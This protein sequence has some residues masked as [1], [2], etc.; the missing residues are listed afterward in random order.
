MFTRMFSSSRNAAV[1][2]L[3]LAWALW[4]CVA[5]AAVAHAEGSESVG[6][7]ETEQSEKAAGQAETAAKDGDPVA[8]SEEEK[9]LLERA[10]A[11]W[12]LRVVASN[13]VYEFY[14]PDLRERGLLPGE[15]AGV[16]YSGYEI[17]RVLTEDDRG[18]VIVRTQQVL[19]PSLSARIAGKDLE[20]YL[21]AHIGEEWVR[22][23]GTW[24][25][26]PFYG[27][28]SRFMHQREEPGSRAMESKPESEPPQGAD[29]EVPGSAAP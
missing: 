13:K 21:K 19:A 29:R 2:V 14:P 12:D 22:I 3:S 28:L 11:Y 27:G 10:R 1:L 17:E 18:V 15:F 16:L 7:E 25:K 6:A 26:K 8:S 24:Y 20:K 23:D 9:A 4:L 5:G